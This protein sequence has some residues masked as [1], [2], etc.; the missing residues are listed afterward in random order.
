MKLVETAA[1]ADKLPEHIIRALIAGGITLLAHTQNRSGR[2]LLQLGGI[3]ER[4]I[5]TLNTLLK[6]YGYAKKALPE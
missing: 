6:E 3:T 1:L 2:E 5:E 4:D